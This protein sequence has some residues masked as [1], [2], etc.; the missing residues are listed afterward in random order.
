[1]KSV[2]LMQKIIV[3]K[4]YRFVPPNRGSFWC[5]LCR[6]IKFP[7]LHLRR[8]EGV[9]AHE[10]RHLERFQASLAAG[11]GI[12]LTPNHP[13][14]ADPVAM[15]FLAMAAPSY[16][17]AMASWHLFQQGWLTA[18]F[19]RSVGGF[20]VNREGVDRQAI[21][22][23][24]DL[25][26]EAK[27]PLVI[28]PE[29]ATSRINDKLQA[30]LDGVAFIARSAAKKR[31]KLSP[32]GK[33]VVHPIAVKY[34][35]RGDV[36]RVCD[37]VLTDIE[38]RLTWQPQRDLPL[39]TRIVKVGQA[40]LSLK[41]L[42]YFGQTESGPFA[43]R[44]QKLIDRLLAPLEQ[45][46]FGRSPSGPVVPRVRNLRSKI[47]PDM[48]AGR[49]DAA[50][51]ARRWRHLADIY[52][53]QQLACYPPDY[54]ANQPSGDRVLEIVEKFEEDLFDKARVHPGRKVVLEVGEAIEVSPER[55]RS[56]PIDPL[57]VSIE[58]SLQ[59]M[60]DRLAA[61]SPRLEG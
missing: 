57:M 2:L 53:A 14:T 25:L 58:S 20:S 35:F 56:A 15:G 44:L 7:A 16:L 31:A 38:T 61:E 41:E 24:V 11:H 54:L 22:M 39:L 60:L 32:P 21:A 8:S 40:L 37:E 50:E 46:W 23:A 12:L 26:A 27:R 52:L 10:I 18:W 33:V 42:E 43:E 13:R 45:Q 36:R 59:F 5:A 29:G 47:L 30:L 17:W 49:V 1:M 28:F 55:D 48:V 6:V 4:P 19:M 9:D 34:F 51:R 3:E